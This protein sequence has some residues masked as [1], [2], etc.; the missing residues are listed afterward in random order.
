[1]PPTKQ[2]LEKAINALRLARKISSQH[3]IRESYGKNVQ[4]IFNY[5]DAKEELETCKIK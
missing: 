2:E 3:F 1:M 4:P 5:Y